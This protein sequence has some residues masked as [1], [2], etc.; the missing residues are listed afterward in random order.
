MLFLKENFVSKSD[1]LRHL[2]SNMKMNASIEFYV[3]SDS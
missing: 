3:S 1:F 2:G